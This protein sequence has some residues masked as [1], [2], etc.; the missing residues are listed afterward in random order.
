[1]APFLKIKLKDLLIRLFL[2]LIQQ[3]M[4]DVD[5]IPPEG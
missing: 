1:M 2:W 4:D 5:G 3:I